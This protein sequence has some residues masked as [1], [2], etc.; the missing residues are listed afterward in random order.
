M[1]NP[2][3]LIDSSTDKHVAPYHPGVLQLD[4]PMF[5]RQLCTDE[6]LPMGYTDADRRVI[7]RTQDALGAVARERSVPVR[8][9]AGERSATA[10]GLGALNQEYG[11]EFYRVPDV[12][13]MGEDE[14]SEAV[15]DA[16]DGDELVID[17]QTHYMAP[18]SANLFP[19]GWLRDLFRQVMPGWWRDLDQDFAW[20]LSY[21]LTNV[22]LRTETA[23]AVLTSSPGTTDLCPLF[24]DEIYATR[25]LVD[26]LA[27]QGRLLN[28][29]VVHA[30]TQTELAAMEEMRDRYRP[31]GW[32]VYTMGA[33]VETGWTEPW[34]LDDEKTG[35]PFL[36]RARDLG[37]NLV[38]THKGL[39]QLAPNGAPRDVGPAA[40]AFPD[41]NFVVYHSG[42]EFP[43]DG[44]P[45]EGPYT[46]QTAD[47]GINRLLRTMDD[48]GIGHGS[49]VYAELGSTWFSVIR[50][51]VEAA[52][53][54]G[55]LIKTFGVDNV[56]WGT[57]SIWYGG[58]QPL[59]DAFRAFQ[60]PEPICEKYGYEQLTAKDKEK[61]LGLNAAR[62]Y[63]IDVEAA[64]RA[65]A[66]DDLA[67]AREAV[68]EYRKRQ[69]P[70][71]R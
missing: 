38:C 34:F 8:A 42:Y 25:A 16:L 29:A 35:L 27:G 70:G 49:N 18:H 37:V 4:R 31:V 33:M 15:A 9:L 22:Y 17:V 53:V 61:I 30:E 46:E 12:A 2:H 10:A 71:V 54:L 67:W 3:P 28:H 19:C 44:H 11:H 48:N 57:D 69:F 66:N 40:R 21:Y 56:I 55:K 43:V 59:I 24:N 13:A 32:K 26:N 39:S 7:R 58:S 62:V 47:I 5:L 23:V 50:R 65:S 63:D 51:P 52:H 20:D 36:T 1:G 68:D 41:I 45:G 64:R 14:A 60:I 6:Y